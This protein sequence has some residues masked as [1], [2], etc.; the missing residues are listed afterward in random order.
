MA[1]PAVHDTLTVEEYLEREK[2]S[3]VK[4]EYHDRA[5]SRCGEVTAP[6]LSPTRPPLEGQQFPFQR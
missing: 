2:I 6:E 5:A 3:L 4:H 1:N